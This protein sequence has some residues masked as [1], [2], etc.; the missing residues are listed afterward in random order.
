M[1][2]SWRFDPSNR[3]LDLTD[4]GDAVWIGCPGDQDLY[5]SFSGFGTGTVTLYGFDAQLN[6]ATSLGTVT[7]SGGATYDIAQYAWVKAEVTSASAGSTTL[8]YSREG[9]H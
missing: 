9:L 5:I 4:S 6:G 7:G 8:G 3:T 1:C 2:Q